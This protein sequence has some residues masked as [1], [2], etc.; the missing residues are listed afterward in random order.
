MD[1]KVYDVLVNISKGNLHQPQIS[2]EMFYEISKQGLVLPTSNRNDLLVLTDKGKQV[3][4]E[5]KA[6]R[7]SMWITVLVTIGCAIVTIVA[8]VVLSIR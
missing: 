3:L 5:E 1:K 8:T 7:K 6:K 4:V 2:T